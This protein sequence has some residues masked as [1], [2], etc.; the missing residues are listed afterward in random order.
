M[1]GCR[2]RVHPLGHLGVLVTRPNSSLSM[3]QLLRKYTDN[4]AC[5]RLLGGLDGEQVYRNLRGVDMV[6]LL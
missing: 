3:L 5:R 6:R 4:Q 1:T 2:R